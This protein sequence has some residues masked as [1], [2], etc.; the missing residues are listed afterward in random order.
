ML[1]LYHYAV[2]DQAVE[3]C[4]YPEALVVL[5]E[6]DRGREGVK[7]CSGGDSSQTILSASPTADDA[8]GDCVI[9]AG[10]LDFFLLQSTTIALH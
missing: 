6:D 10:A 3:N 1:T 4:T 2:L 9:V 7:E 5:L 8:D